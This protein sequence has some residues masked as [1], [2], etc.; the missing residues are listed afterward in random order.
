MP[1]SPCD[2][3]LM[4]GAESFDPG[5]RSPVTILGMFVIFAHS[6]YVWRG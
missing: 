6:K 4:L 5:L 2:I 1:T 3:K